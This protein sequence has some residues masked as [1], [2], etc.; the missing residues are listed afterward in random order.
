MN[1][2]E[3]NS[4]F[5]IDVE[6]FMDS[7]IYTI[8]N[9]YRYPDKVINYINSRKTP[10][11]KSGEDKRNNIINNSI[12]FDDRRL[13]EVN[14]DVDI[15]YNFLCDLLKTE[16]VDHYQRTIVTNKTKL[17]HKGFNDYENCYWYPHNDTGLNAIVYLNEETTA[18]TNLYAPQLIYPK[19]PRE[20]EHLW[21]WKP[22][23]LWPLAKTITARYNTMSIFD[24]HKFYH[25]MSV[26]DELWFKKY[27]LNQVFFLK[28]TEMNK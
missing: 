24:G 10:L 27:R 1:I 11:W 21:P 26:N 28:P 7:K 12:F 8:S 2:F 18:G 9:F 14:P 20:P 6:E 22:R 15:V 16:P 13:E 17:L 25:G 19:N 4:S 5:D 23:H 3:I